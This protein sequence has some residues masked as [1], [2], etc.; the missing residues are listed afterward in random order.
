MIVEHFVKQPHG[1]AVSVVPYQPDLASVS[2]AATILPGAADAGE[3]GVTV[4]AGGA[5]FSVS[6]IKIGMLI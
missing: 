1:L 5:S 2:L 4:S 6:S 3:T